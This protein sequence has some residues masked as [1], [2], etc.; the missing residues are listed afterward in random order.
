MG[1]DSDMANQWS[2]EGLR[3]ALKKEAASTGTATANV[4]FQE[5]ISPDQLSGAAQQAI[6][7]AS[8]KTG[9]AKP[10]ISRVHKLAKSVSVK[11][12][13]DTIAEMANAPGVK[14]ILP[15]QVEDIY[16]KPVKRRVF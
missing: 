4:F 7:Q 2:P 8:V 1:D 16:P 12:D 9:R 10:E 3:K 5:L 14:T 13:P 11:G 15:S 6:E